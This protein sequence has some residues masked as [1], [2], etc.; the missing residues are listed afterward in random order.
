MLPLTFSIEMKTSPAAP[1]PPVPA[2]RST[3]TAMAD[4]Q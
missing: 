2:A 3:V 4:P 1:P